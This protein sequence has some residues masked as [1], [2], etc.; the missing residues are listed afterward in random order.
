MENFSQF[1]PQLYRLKP[2]VIQAVLTDGSD[3]SNQAIIE[4]TKDSLTPAVVAPSGTLAIHTLAGLVRVD[5]GDYVIR[6]IN[7]DFYVCRPDIF[8]AS[9]N[10]NVAGRFANKPTDAQSRNWQTASGEAVSLVTSGRHS[11]R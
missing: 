8:E 2:M 7:S 1:V 6:G 5:P 10:A 11:T 3:E 9:H 4:W